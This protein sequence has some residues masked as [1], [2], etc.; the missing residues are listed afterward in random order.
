MPDCSPLP[1]TMSY[2]LAQICKLHRQRADD[3]LGEIGLHVGQEMLLCV[4]WEREGVTQTELGDSLGVQPATVTNALKRLERK[5]LVMRI[6]DTTDQRVS[7]VSLTA[8]GREVRTD[9]EERWAQL[10][11]ASFAGITAPER[12]VLRGLLSR[13]QR[14]LAGREVRVE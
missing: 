11:R 3:L 13:V 7:R 5:G 4:L 12:D 8:E 9:V 6:A 1:V 14:N 2:L 10:E